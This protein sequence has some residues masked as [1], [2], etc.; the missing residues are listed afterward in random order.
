MLE[1]LEPGGPA[2]IVDVDIR[3]W[4]EAARANPVLYR[5][6]Q[7]T[8]IVLATIGLTPS[9][10]TTLVLKGGALMALAFKSERVTGDVD[11]SASVGPADYDKMLV[12]ELNAQLPR[13]AIQLGYLDL[14]CR[15]Q[16]VIKRPRP[17]N[18]ENMDFP[19]LL[20]RIGS[21]VRGGREQAQLEAGQAT[22][23][24]DVEISFRDQVYQFQE[25]NLANAGAAV[26][27]FTLHEIIAE[28]LRALL[29]QPGRDRYRRQDVYDIAFLLDD[30][31][32][33]KHDLERIHE[34]LVE[35]CGT[36]GITPTVG[37]LADPEVRRRAEADW[38]T[39]K[40]ELASLPPFDERYARIEAFYRSLPW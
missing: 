32:L 29:Q 20:V 40:L 18:F 17:Q 7:V 10:A 14:I 5:N 23:V 15:V 33:Q 27:A 8:E 26:R 16:R 21:A 9:L 2:E 11:F 25:L 28:K 4:V 24:V 13:V 19:A 22:R 37:S 38:G 34:T 1:G 6:R 36:R 3:A 30:H 12:Q 35:K 39:L 31:P